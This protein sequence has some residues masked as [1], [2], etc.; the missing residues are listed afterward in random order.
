MDNEYLVEVGEDEEIAKEVDGMEDVEEDAIAI[1]KRSQKK[2]KMRQASK[3]VKKSQKRRNV[4]NKGTSQLNFK[5]NFLMHM[6]E[7]ANKVCIFF[8]CLPFSFSGFVHLL[9][10]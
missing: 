9:F 7:K 1:K 4:G 2:H 6:P 5:R 3:G 8:F 10:S